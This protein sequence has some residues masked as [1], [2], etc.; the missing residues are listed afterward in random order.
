AG[1]DAK[2]KGHDFRI[3][4]DAAPAVARHMSTTGG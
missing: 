3:A 4:R 2:P 1:V